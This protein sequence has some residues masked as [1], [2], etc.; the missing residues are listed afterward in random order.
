MDPQSFQQVGRH[1]PEA[2][3]VEMRRIEGREWWLWGFAV[4]VTL[5]LTLGII[6]FTF[7]WF[8]RETNV[9]YWFDLREWV[10]GLAALVLLFDFYA[11]Y[12]HLQL[13]RIRRQ[14]AERDQL[15]QLISENAA[16]MIALV[17][18]DGRRLYNSPAYLKVLGYSHEDLK[19]TSSIDQIH[20]DDRERV[21]QAAEKARLSGLG[22]MM[23]YRVRHKDG[24]WRT[25]ESTASPIRNARGKA[26]KLVIV[27]R[28]ITERKRAEE[29]LAHNA[30][31]D[32]LTNLPNR[33]LFLDRLQHALTLSKRHTNYKFAVLLIDVDEFKVVNDSLGLSA[34]DELLIQVA[35]RLR[36]SVRRV[37]T[38]SRPRMAEV[39]DRTAND[40]NLARLGGDEFTILLDDIRDPIEAVRVAERI[41][42]EL[43]TPFFIN[44]E[45]IV[46]SASIGIASSVS[47]HTQAEDLVRDA[48][49]AMYRAKRAGKAR[50]EV[51]DTAMHANAVKRLRMETDLRKA[52]DQGEFRVYYQPIVWL[53]TGKIAGFE[54]LTRWQRP[55]G[56]VP[57]MDF[58]GVAEETGLIIPMNRNLLREACEHL[59]YWQAEFPSDPPLTMSVNVTSKEFAQPDL[60][61]EIGRSLEQTGIDPACLQVEIIETIA[62]GDAEKSGYVLAQLKSLGVRLSIDDFG[63]GY[64]SL[65]RLRRM[66]VD[67][68]KIDRA[69]ISNMDSDPENCAIVRAIIILAHNL[70]LKVVAEGTEREEQINLLKQYNCEMV[71]GYLFSRPADDLTM[72]RLLASNRS[73]SAAAGGR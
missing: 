8:E 45:E 31:H 28:D 32:G 1:S 4:A 3:P 17:D 41:Q 42:G 52:L 2:I 6:S 70:G 7:P 59:R 64:S 19:D 71:Q 13:H 25:L 55:E 56:M 27:N 49:I 39:P 68:L 34:G 51:S 18:A 54:A 36:E 47:P 16:D 53:Q 5:A 26:D 9:S 73:A 69:F 44:Q 10:R 60:A 12:Q 33:A 66:P 15:F 72:L 11:I 30:F 37:D 63:T 57:P 48:D 62:M 43:A 22:E 46:I 24:S 20:P 67:T 14:L 58:I 35:Q 29:L 50:C 61:G 21:I 23:E 40:G 65:S 38:V